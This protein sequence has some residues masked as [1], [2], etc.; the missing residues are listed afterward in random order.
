[1]RY[2]WGLNYSSGIANQTWG[3]GNRNTATCWF[4]YDNPAITDPYVSYDGL[5]GGSPSAFFVLNKLEWN[6]MDQ[7]MAI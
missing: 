5:D 4:I 3:L 6:R 1:M 2:V 7:H